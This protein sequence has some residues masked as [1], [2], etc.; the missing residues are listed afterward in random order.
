MKGGFILGSGCEIPM[1]CK[2]ENLMAMMIS[3]R[4]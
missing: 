3:L 1:N 4:S 2:P